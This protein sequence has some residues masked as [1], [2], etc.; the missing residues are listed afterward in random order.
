MAQQVQVKQAEIDVSKLPFLEAA[1]LR[2][3]QVY[4]ECRSENLKRA[5][6][7]SA[8]VAGLRYTLR[9]NLAMHIELVR[10]VRAV[11]LLTV[12]RMH[13]DTSA[14]HLYHRTLETIILSMTWA[15]RPWSN[16]D[17]GDIKSAAGALQAHLREL[18]AYDPSGELKNLEGDLLDYLGQIA[19]QGKVDVKAAVEKQ[20]NKL[21]DQPLP[22]T[23]T[24]A[25]ALGVPKEQVEEWKKDLEDLNN[26]SKEF[27]KD[28]KGANNVEGYVKG[29][30]KFLQSPI[31]KKLLEKAGVENAAAAASAVGNAAAAI[32]GFISL[33][34]NWDQLSDG[35]KALQIVGILAEVGLAIQVFMTAATA[36]IKTGILMLL[37]M[38][39]QFIDLGISL[40]PDGDGSKPHGG[41]GDDGESKD[42]GGFADPDVQKDP[43]D[44]GGGYKVKPDDL[45]KKPK[46]G[47]GDDAKDRERFEK[48]RG[49]ARED[50]D[51]TVQDKVN[52][53]ADQDKL[54]TPPEKKDQI[55]KQIDR[56]KE[57]TMTASA[58]KPIDF[59]DKCEE[60]NIKQYDSDEA[61]NLYLS[62][63]RLPLALENVPDSVKE[64]AQKREN[65]R[66]DLI[67][68][69]EQK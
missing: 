57:G 3:R 1:R 39:L 27:A 36:G 48:A 20:I 15:S 42:G 51:K 12:D 37:V 47:G 32:L 65:S 52:K 22:D 53:L 59:K 26:A 50:Y 67:R 56:T 28:L 35:R 2:E 7:Y 55:K 4:R 6:R 30:A 61:V 23:E 21:R 25:K 24:L 64:K 29:F 45:G 40:F 9:S 46:P 68:T 31:T 34:N 14:L 54:G 8:Q 69:A 33:I 58:P 60:K 11:D 17:Q 63:T 5:Y 38:L 62:L 18:R 41:E 16:I 49:K 43:R 10:S 44:D 19:G 13:V 66:R